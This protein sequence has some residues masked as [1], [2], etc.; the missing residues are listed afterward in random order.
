MKEGLLEHT[1]PALIDKLIA[2]WSNWDYYE[3]YYL[4]VLAP[5]IVRSGCSAQ[6]K[7]HEKKILTE[8]RQVLSQGEWQQLPML[9]AQRRD[10]KLKEL[11]SAREQAKALEDAKRQRRREEEARV[12]R[13][14]A[15]V[16]RLEDVFESDF[17][18]A[19]G[20]LAADPDAELLSVD[21]YDE[22]KTSFVRDWAA[23]ELRQPLDSEQAAAVAAASGDIQ[24]VARAGSGK[25]RTLVTRAIFL[26]KHCRVSPS[27]IL[28]LAF[29]KKAAG[30]I[31]SRLTQTLGENLPHVMTFH[32][33]AH[34]LVHPE[35][36]LVFDDMSA[37]QLGYSREVQEVIDKHVRSEEYGD[38]VRD[39][40]LAHFREDWER[41]VDGRF[42]LTMDE[43]LAHRR[44]LPRETLK[45]DYVKSYGEKV[46]ANALFE[47][48]VD[49][50]YESSHRWNDVNY[51]P[52]FKIRMGPRGGGVIIE[53][54][55][56][57]GDADYDQMSQEKRQFWAERDEWTFVEFSPRHLTKSGQDGF[58]RLLLQKIEKAGVSYRRLS[59]EEIWE[60]VRKRAR[61]SFTAAMET[62]VGRCRKRDLT[63]DDL[64]WLVA[65][66]NPCSTAEAM[67]LDVGV[68]VYRSYLQRL[69]ANKKEDFDGL[70]WRSV[71]L[72][73]E[74]QTRFV[75]DKG[76]ERGDVTQLRFVMIDEFQDFSQM[77][78]ELV[79]VIRSANPGAQFFCVG[80]DWQ[81]ING[82]AGSAPR[83]F[84]NFAAYFRD[85]SRRHIRTNYRSARSVV[86]VGNALMD[87]QGPVAT[88]ER[89]DDGLVRLCKL[90]EFKPS[91]SEQEIHNRDEITP[92]LLRLV[93]SFL[94]RGMDVVMLSRTNS[95]PW[96]DRRGE[97]TTG[98][99]DGLARFLHH[100]RSYLPEED[101]ERV[102]ISTTH[103]YKGQEHSAVVVLDAIERR[104]PLIHSNWVFLRVFG[105]TIDQI[106]DEER[107]LFYVAVT[108]AKD[109]LALLTD[110]PSQSPYLDDIH[111]HVRLTELSCTDLPPVPS[112]DSARLEIR[113][114]DAYDV[115]DQLKDLKYRWD[116]AGRYW[117]RSVMAEGFSF[118]GLLEQPWAREGVRLEV[119]SETGE[120]LQR[121]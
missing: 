22:L 16:A 45:G 101:R 1:A 68:S 91:A 102:T 80:D 13:K 61:D 18:S 94:D 29:N 95:V 44:E 115:R 37:D 65:R 48:G 118:D 78:L 109:S 49:Y 69:V 25:T 51:R 97:R 89:A 19:D 100:V 93:R 2:C 7:P 60:T 64:E 17:L 57:E 67:F 42:Q 23:R 21:E 92:A 70:M 73:R 77:F 81:A 107:R 76:R 119:Y 11:D 32:A 74:G 53:Y 58:V 110:T 63:P 114:F 28:L 5:S 75:R 27:K 86:E 36:D 35:E 46:I 50:K 59:E 84:S 72:V 47:H 112:L 111:R 12:A 39:L 30:E 55:G 103:Q 117:R 96:Y 52:D 108:R 99:S 62:F 38:R 4:T 34:A 3:E 24:V 90:D 116:A 98:A 8:L 82:F 105:D 15:L 85:T 54:F 79:D 33:L 120:L 20:V 6:L 83:F 88:V 56:L 104:Y 31:K 43:F 121:R 106:E 10:D 113:V 66:H 40:M 9:I 41:I 87:G 26:Q 14:R 71:S